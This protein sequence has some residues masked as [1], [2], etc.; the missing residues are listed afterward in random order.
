[1]SK[2]ISPK[3]QG[4]EV[5]YELHPF[6]WKAFQNLRATVMGKV[7]GQVVQARQGDFQIHYSHDQSYESD[8]VVETTTGRFL[9]E[10]K[11]ASEVS[12]DVVLS[13]V[14]AAAV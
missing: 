7:W 10:P 8:F 9:F 12:D 1:M 4:G 6:G 14:D 2:S 3:V 5:T 11:R 13:K